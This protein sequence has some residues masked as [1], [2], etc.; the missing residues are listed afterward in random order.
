MKTQ[1]ETDHHVWHHVDAMFFEDVAVEV[2]VHPGWMYGPMKN[3]RLQQFFE[4]NKDS[5]MVVDKKLGFS[6]TT[7]RFDA[8]SS[9]VHSFH[10]LLEEGIGLRHIVD[11]FFVLRKCHTDNTDITDIIRVLKSIGLAKFTGAVMWVMQEVCVMPESELLCSPNEKE[12]TFLLEEI[13]A[14][15]NFGQTRTDGKVR[16]SFSRWMMMVKHY[17]GEVLWMLPWKGWHKVWRL[18]N[19]R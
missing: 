6:H 11:Y 8:V 5:Q 16:N 7:A 18:V 15:G 14:G 13:M 10:H 1:C 4:R 9:L 3:H 19:Q 17:P 12:G 2:H